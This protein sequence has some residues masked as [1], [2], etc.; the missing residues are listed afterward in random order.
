MAVSQNPRQSLE[1][2]LKALRSAD[3]VN[4]A[5]HVL[6]GVQQ[7]VRSQKRQVI[8][9]ALGAC[10]ASVG[11]LHFALNGDPFGFIGSI[12][13]T[14]VMI[15]VTSKSARAAAGLT[16]LESGKS[17]LAAWRTELE[18]QLQHTFIAQLCAVL[19]L[20]LTLWVVWRNAF[21]SLK[22]I[23]FLVMAAVICTFATYQRL[24]MKPTL[25]RELE[26]L[27]EDG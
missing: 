15:V 1:D 6:N 8:A 26:G 14:A 5:Q 19:F 20:A 25:E 27:Q 18:R 3:T 13:S 7:R 9:A 2:Q 17:L 12:L 22:S 4:S 11:V 21:P 10:V 24:V 23:L 16:S